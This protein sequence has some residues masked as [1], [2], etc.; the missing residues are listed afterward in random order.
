MFKKKEIKELEDKLKSTLVNYNL[1]VEELNEVGS[2]N[3]KIKSELAE[4]LIL[5]TE[6]L[7][8]RVVA[9]PVE[10]FLILEE[11][12]SASQNFENIKKEYHSNLKEH[13]Y[14]TETIVGASATIMGISVATLG[15]T[16]ATAMASTYGIASTGTAISALS[17]AAASN[18]ILA[19]LGGGAIVAGGGGMAAGTTLLALFG[20]IGIAASTL[21]VLG[22]GT[23]SFLKA[24]KKIKELKREIK[25]LKALITEGCPKAKNELESDSKLITKI[26]ETSQPHYDYLN[27]YAPLNYDKFSEI[28]KDELKSYMKT[29]ELLTKNLN[30]VQIS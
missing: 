11:Y 2:S 28:E 14:K 24:N 19:W 21:S 16:A 29:I 1:A 23:Y 30:G 27:K 7:L 18:A 12:K 20:P 9:L 4:N 17:G 6:R 3:Y 8:T 13:S 26:A 15:P 10:Y 22:S 25:N 5:K